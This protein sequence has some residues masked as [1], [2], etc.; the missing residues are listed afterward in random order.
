MVKKEIE[1][2][3]LKTLKYF[4]QSKCVFERGKDTVLFHILDLE[5]IFTKTMF[6][7][8]HAMHIKRALHKMD[9]IKDR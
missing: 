7:K 4:I 9:N 8:I 2:N 5:K 3:M 1:T 6:K